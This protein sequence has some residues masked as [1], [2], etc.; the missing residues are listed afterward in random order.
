MVDTGSL[1]HPWQFLKNDH[2]GTIHE[3][4]Q[5]PQD[6]RT[7]LAAG[8]RVSSGI[9]SLSA[10]HHQANWICFQTYAAQGLIAKTKFVRL[11][12]PPVLRK[13]LGGLWHTRRRNLPESP[14][15]KPCFITTVRVASHRTDPYNA[16]TLK[17][18]RLQEQRTSTIMAASRP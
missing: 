13:P 4:R 3:S 2:Q 16:P 1:S 11:T 15:P 10:F 12:Q 6:T 9:V 17:P 7:N 14:G 18:P 8:F 5:I